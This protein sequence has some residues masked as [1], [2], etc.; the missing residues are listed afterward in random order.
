MRGSSDDGT[1]DRESPVVIGGLGGSGTR[2]VAEIAGGLGV[3]LGASLNAA[4]DNL[5]FTLLLNRPRWFGRQPDPEAVEAALRLFERATLGGLAGGPSPRESVLLR[6]VEEGVREH[7]QQGGRIGV[8]ETAVDELMSARPPDL[9]GVPAWGWKE[10]NAHVFLPDL[11]RCYPRMK[12]IHVVRHGLDMAYSSNRNQLRHWGALFGVP[13]PRLRTRA[14]RSQLE[15]WSRT[16]RRVSELARDHAGIMLSSFDALCADPVAGV[17]ELAA[18]I[19][20]PCSHERAEVLARGVRTPASA[21]RY[22]QR[23]THRFPSEELREV[24]A[25]GFDILP[26]LPRRDRWRSAIARSV[27]WGRPAR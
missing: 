19:G 3:Y 15:Y 5:W 7:R 17:R 12:Y 4:R 6:E 21:G 22:R 16:N 2:V 25:M 20:L 11:L 1:L 9:R 13:M 14:A 27:R 24:R 23:R 10:P 26:P 18:F 8:R